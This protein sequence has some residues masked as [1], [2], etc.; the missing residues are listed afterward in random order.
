M[1]AM[2][3]QGMAPGPPPELEEERVKYLSE[4]EALASRPARP[5][6]DDDDLFGPA[7]PPDAPP[8]RA[9]PSEIKEA[10]PIPVV[11]EEEKPA[12]EEKPAAAPAPEAAAKKGRKYN[13]RFAHLGGG[14]RC[15]KCDKIVGFAD[16]VSALNSTWHKDCFRC[17]T[18]SMV[19]RQG[20]WREH[21]NW[22]Y[23][24]SCHAAGFG[25]KGF[26]FG[27]SVAMNVET[28]KTGKPAQGEVDERP[29]FRALERRGVELEE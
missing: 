18:C 9:L 21:N 22:P 5:V 25:I 16:K 7:P 29:L 13:S 6:R 17:S 12:V 24:S 11:D 28:G 3:W 10:P 2:R 8:P 14:A 4:Q 27:G 20:Q 19:L 23:C 26:G 1:S 15:R